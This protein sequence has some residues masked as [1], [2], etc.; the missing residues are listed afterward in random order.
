MSSGQ[1]SAR[2]GTSERH[3]D[4]PVFGAKPDCGGSLKLLS[5][6]AAGMSAPDFFE[7]SFSGNSAGLTFPLVKPGGDWHRRYQPILSRQ[8]DAKSARQNGCLLLCKPK[9]KLLGELPTGRQQNGY[10]SKESARVPYFGAGAVQ[11]DLEAGRFSAKHSRELP[12][13]RLSRFRAPAT[14]DNSRFFAGRQAYAHA[15]TAGKVSIR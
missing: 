4:L 3:C 13:C 1:D 12:P 10:P 15:G 2:N 5:V 9:C 14:H 8:V 11:S 7:Y 6:E